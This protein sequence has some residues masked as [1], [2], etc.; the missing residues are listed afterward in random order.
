M[1]DHGSEGIVGNVCSGYFGVV[2]QGIDDQLE[3]ESGRCCLSNRRHENNVLFGSFV[4]RVKG[5]WV[6]GRVDG[7]FEGLRGPTMQTGQGDCGDAHEAQDT[8]AGDLRHDPAQ[9]FTERKVSST[10]DGR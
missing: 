8:D 6:E 3:V 2:G 10:T 5:G 9:A 7:G 1:F 4:Q